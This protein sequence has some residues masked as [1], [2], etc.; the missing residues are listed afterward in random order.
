MDVRKDVQYATEEK[1]FGKQNA[2]RARVNYKYT[3]R[4]LA[5]KTNFMHYASCFIAVFKAHVFAAGD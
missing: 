5:F 3:C 4:G 2:E 1:Q